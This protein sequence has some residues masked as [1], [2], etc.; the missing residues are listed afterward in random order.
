MIRTR[1]QQKSEPNVRCVTFVLPHRDSC[2]SAANCEQTVIKGEKDRVGAAISTR[3]TVWHA[4]RVR[5]FQFSLL[6]LYGHCINLPSVPGWRYRH[7]YFTLVSLYLI[8]TLEQPHQ[9]F[10]LCEHWRRAGT[11]YTSKV[12]SSQQS[13][14]PAHASPPGEP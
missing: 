5:L 9:H 10:A 2:P 4:Q 11:R 8:R 1:H 14:H 12:A 3:Q 13:G 6:R 7:R